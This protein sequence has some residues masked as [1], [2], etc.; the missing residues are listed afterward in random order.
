MTKIVAELASNHGGNWELCSD[1]IKSAADHGASY[2]KLQLFDADTL[3]D[4]DPQKAFLKQSQVTRPVLDRMLSVAAKSGITLTAS[5]FGIPQAIEAHAAGLKIVKI[6]SG[7]SDRD[8]LIEA[9]RSRFDE[10]WLSFGLER[11]D[12]ES[13]QVGTIGFYGVTQ[14]PTPYLRGL[15]VLHQCPKGLRWGWSD[16]GEN[17]EVAQEAILHGAAYVEVHYTLGIGR[18]CRHDAWDRDRTQLAELRRFIDD[19]SW[20]PGVPEYDAAVTKYVGRWENVK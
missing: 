12:F 8:D 2:V 16:H 13:S 5:V 14:Y 3:H 9:C 11:N 17:L 15:A 4:L 1:L 18:G 20:E 19:V 6:G 10:L 7:D